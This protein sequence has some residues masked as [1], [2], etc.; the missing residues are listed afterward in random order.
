METTIR[1]FVVTDPP[2]SGEVYEQALDAK[3]QQSRLKLST[4]LVPTDRNPEGEEIV[5][6]V[7]MWP[8]RDKPDDIVLTSIIGEDEQYDTVNLTVYADPGEPA[9]L[10]LVVDVDMPEPAL[11]GEHKSYNQLLATPLEYDD[12]FNWFLSKTRS[13]TQSHNGAVGRVK[14]LGE[15]EEVGQ[16]EGDPQD[17]PS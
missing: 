9:T 6:S 7:K 5:L 8:N 14:R 15:E 11:I 10:S 13:Q 16:R 17:V 4:R 2:T 1:E 3:R 12:D